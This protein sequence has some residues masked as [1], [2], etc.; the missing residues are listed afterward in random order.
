M[1]TSLCVF[2]FYGYGLSL[3]GRVPFVSI[4]FFAVSI[5]LIQYFLGKYWLS[6]FSLGPMELLWRRLSHVHIVNKSQKSLNK[7]TN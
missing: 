3:M 1:Q 2:L 4:L 6:K 7:H 5:L